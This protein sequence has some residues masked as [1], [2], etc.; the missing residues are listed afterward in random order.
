MT[1]DA[2]I[3]L[4]LGLVFIFIIAFII[5]GLPRFRS[6]T[7]NNELTTNTVNLPDDSMGIAAKER[8]AQGMF[9][10]VGRLTQ[11]R[12]DE[13]PVVSKNEGAV[14]FEMPLPEGTSAVK[15][16]LF[17]ETPIDRIKPSALLSETNEKTKVNKPRSVEPALP[18]TYV[19]S[20]GDNLAIIA[21]KFYGPDEGNKKINV[22]KIFEANRKLLNSVDEIYVGQE[23]TIPP[24]IDKSG[25]VFSG[26]L[27]DKVKSIGR[28]LTSDDPSKAPRTG[29]SKQYVVREGDSLWRIAAQQL[30]DGTRY[31]ELN[32]LNADILGKEDYLAVGMRLRIPAR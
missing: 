11:E 19:V 2:K 29:R 4:L 17:V 27:F 1:S 22:T 12:V 3:G 32:E 6:N 28:K 7:N 23:L 18:K 16:D 15:D 31:K 5:N 30:G 26:S 9:G 13:V 21:Q 8:K 24:L 25:S 10:R 14:R 20:E